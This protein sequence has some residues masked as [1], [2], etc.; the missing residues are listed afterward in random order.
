MK[1]YLTYLHWY[2][3]LALSPDVC[4]DDFINPP[5]YIRTWCHPR[6]DLSTWRFGIM[7]RM[8]DWVVELSGEDIRVL[9]AGEASSVR[10]LGGE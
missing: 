9:T 7:F 5:V 6:V 10:S 1:Q 2:C 8:Y 3:S 4:I